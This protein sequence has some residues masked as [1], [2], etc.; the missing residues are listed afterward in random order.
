VL[1]A[2]RDDDDGVGRDAPVLAA[3]RFE[4]EASLEVHEL[5]GV[6]VGVDPVH[7]DA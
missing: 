5:H 3:P 4:P 2:A 7:V 1:V 6:S